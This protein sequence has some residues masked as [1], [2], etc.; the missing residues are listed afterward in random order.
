MALPFLLTFWMACLIQAFFA[1]KDKWRS[2]RNGW[3]PRAHDYWVG[4]QMTLL[5]C[6]LAPLAEAVIGFGIIEFLAVLQRLNSGVSGSLNVNCE[7][8]GGSHEPWQ[9]SWGL[10]RNFALLDS[11]GDVMAQLSWILLCWCPS[12]RRT[13]GVVEK[14]RYCHQV[15]TVW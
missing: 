10:C 3:G 9:A 4:F 7:R 1:L 11:R 14:A 12:W 2:C 8:S 5:S 13:G 15:Q 6:S